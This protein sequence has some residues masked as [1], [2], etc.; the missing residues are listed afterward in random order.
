MTDLPVNLSTAMLETLYPLQMEF[1]RPI[2]ISYPLFMLDTINGLPPRRL[3]FISTA[4][5]SIF[6]MVSTFESKLIQYRQC[7]Y[8]ESIVSE[9]CVLI[10]N[11]PVNQS[12]YRFSA[13]DIENATMIIPI[14]IKTPGFFYDHNLPPN[15]RHKPSIQPSENIRI[16]N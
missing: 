11:E 5:E 7:V 14:R 15:R 4:S 16:H 12:G 9:Y 8:L 13:S 6:K 2:L 10:Q 1:V 3:S